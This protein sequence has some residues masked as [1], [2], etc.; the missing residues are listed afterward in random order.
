MTKWY[1]LLGNNITL[2]NSELTLKK[3]SVRLDKL[4]LMN[5]VSPKSDKHIIP[6]YLKLLYGGPGAFMGQCEVCT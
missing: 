5:A 6:L 3:S 4:G 1:I 2:L